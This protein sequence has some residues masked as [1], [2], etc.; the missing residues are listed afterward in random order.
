MTIVLERLIAELEEDGSLDQPDHVRQRLEALDRLDSFLLNG[1]LPAAGARPAK[2]G[3]HRRARMLYEKLELANVE[4]YKAIRSEIQRGAGR[5]ALLHWASELGCGRS[6]SDHING[7]GYDGLDELISGV[8]QLKKPATAVTPLEAEMVLYQPTPAR[9][10]F[11]LMDRVA[12]NQDD[13]LIDLGSGLGH[14]SLVAA[15][16]TDARC[17]GVELEAENADCARRSAHEL[18]LNNATFIQQDA[19]AADFSGGT[20]FYLYT[21][22]VGI[23]LRT[24]L[25]SL[26]REAARREIRICT[27]GPCTATVA[28]EQWLKAA[29]AQKADRIGVFCSR[30]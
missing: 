24:V 15:I 16:C 26:R 18:N 8:L 20:V 2:G 12:L 3:I 11:D 10:I 28:E 4:L 17:I 1:E 23:I 27:F 9:H 6:A 19:R 30:D 5:S 25:D 7:E 13:V 29:G 21:P 22:F 14:V